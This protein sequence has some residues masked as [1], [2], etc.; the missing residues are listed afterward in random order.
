MGFSQNQTLI[1]NLKHQLDHEQQDT[2]RVAIMLKLYG[3]FLDSP[4]P[5][6]SQVFVEKAL[7]L[8]TKI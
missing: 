2:N 6:S 8:A 4:N 1:D 5:D 7:D 3:A